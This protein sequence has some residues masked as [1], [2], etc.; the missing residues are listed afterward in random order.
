M[1]DRR[2]G[3]EAVARGHDVCGLGKELLN[4]VDVP[5]VRCMIA[6][7]Q[8]Q[9]DRRP[10][11]LG[12]CTVHVH[13]STRRLDEANNELRLRRVD[14]FVGATNPAIAR[15]QDAQPQTDGTVVGHGDAQSHQRIE[16]RPHRLH[17]RVGFFYIVHRGIVG[18]SRAE[19]PPHETRL[20]CAKG[21][22]DLRLPAIERGADAVHPHKSAV[23][24]P[25]EERRP[26]VG[27]TRH[28][29]RIP[30]KRGRLDRISHVAFREPH[31]ARGTHFS[32]PPL[33]LGFA[34]DREDHRPPHQDLFHRFT[35]ADS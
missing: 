12:R 9:T 21:P 24:H 11:I 29:A 7:T 27:G 1:D 6:S 8:P 14:A 5:A 10:E 15:V 25:T 17:P 2:L 26:T 34:R 19:R 30:A 16:M 22:A 18:Q 35:N 3:R 23:L 33:H 32:G 31:A 13:A 20:S 28:P 4:A